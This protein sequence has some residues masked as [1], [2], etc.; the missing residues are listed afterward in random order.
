MVI[1]SQYSGLLCGEV[2]YASGIERGM[3]AVEEI[4][5]L[6]GAC[7]AGGINLEMGDHVI[8]EEMPEVVVFSQN[9]LAQI[10]LGCTFGKGV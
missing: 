8:G 5:I 3:F 4:A 9:V 1:L 10:C 2:A 6:I 7:L